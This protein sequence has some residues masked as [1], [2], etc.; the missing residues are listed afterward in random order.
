MSRRKTAIR[1]IY[2]TGTI[3]IFR[4]DPAEHNKNRNERD[5]RD[6]PWLYNAGSQSGHFCYEKGDELAR[7]RGK[8]RR[9]LENSPPGLLL[10]IFQIFSIFMIA[11]D[12]QVEDILEREGIGFLVLLL[13]LTDN[14]PELLL[15][16]PDA[17]L[18]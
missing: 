8:H 10:C 13:D 7:F 5:Y 15:V 11:V 14:G 1:A 6:T 18:F 4:D 3:Q 2:R 16:V 17:H 12:N 9:Y